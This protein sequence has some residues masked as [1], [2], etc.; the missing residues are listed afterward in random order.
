MYNESE[1]ELKRT[2][3]GVFHNFNELR[4]DDKLKF[5][6]EDFIVFVICDGYEHI[7]ESFKIYAN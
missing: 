7:P 1:E 3:S 6:K 4:L 2:L 5:N